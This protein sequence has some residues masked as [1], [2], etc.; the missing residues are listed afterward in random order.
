[1]LSDMEKVPSKQF[2]GFAPPG[3]P[4]KEAGCNTGEEDLNCL[5][6]V[7]FSSHERILGEGSTNYSLPAFLLKWRS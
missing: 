1:M 2:R 4:I 3:P 7:A 5:A 6:V